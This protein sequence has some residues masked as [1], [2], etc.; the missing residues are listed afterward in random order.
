[1]NNYSLIP[2]F[3]YDYSCSDLLS[4][5]KALFRPFPNAAVIGKYFGSSHVYFTNYARTGLRLILS[6]LS[7]VKASEQL[8]IGVQVYNCLTVFQAIKKA[9]HIPVFI[10]INA[11]FTMDAEDLENKAD[12]IDALIVNHTFGIPADFEKLKRI[13][14]DKPVIEDCAHSLFSTYRGKPTGSFGDAAVFSFGF[15]KYPSVGKGGMTLINHRSLLWNFNNLYEQL[16]GPKKIGE[17]ITPFQSF[18]YAL[19]FNPFLYGTF[20]YPVGKRMDSGL[21]FTGKF[22]ITEAKGSRAV[23]AVVLKKFALLLKEKNH[24]QRENGHFLFDRLKDIYDCVAESKDKRFNYYLFPIKHPRRDQIVEYLFRKGIEA[25]KHFTRS[26]LWAKAFGYEEGSC[27]N[28]E[29]LVKEI[30]VI[31]ANYN[32]TRKQLEYTTAALDRFSQNK[33]VP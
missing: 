2:K 19:A 22:I 4:G 32:L 6:S 7:S 14:I 8:R 5:L 12:Q 28:A 33:P 10:D 20:T 16:P 13:V 25:G 17:F 18:A 27:P 23:V 30:F 29:K 11:D 31:P 21:D 3:N 24:R 15:G 1:M 26:I 9:G